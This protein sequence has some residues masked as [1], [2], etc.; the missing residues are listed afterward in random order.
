MRLAAELDESDENPTSTSSCSSSPSATTTTTPVAGAGKGLF[1]STLK[2]HGLAWT[3]SL[4]RVAALTLAA[5]EA[6]EPV[7]LVGDTGSGKTTAAQLA[8]ALR[9]RPLIAI[10]CSRHTEA[11]DFVGGFR[12]VR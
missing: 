8:A 7:L 6:A 12:P 2:R 11:A 1:S 10:N 9:R 3:P 4:V 5:L